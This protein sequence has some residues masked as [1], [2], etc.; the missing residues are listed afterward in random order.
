MN[1]VNADVDAIVSGHT[2]LAYN[3][4]VPV[5][6]W[7][8]PRAS[9]RSVRSS[10]RA[11]T[12]PTSTSSC[13]PS[14]PA[15]D[16]LAMAKTRPSSPAVAD[17][18]GR[19][20]PPRRSSTTWRRPGG[21]AGCPSSARSR[22][23]SSRPSSNGT[24]ENR[25]GESTLGNL[26]AEVQRW[27]TVGDRRGR[28]DRVHEPRA[29]SVP[30]WWAPARGR[31]GP[32]LPQAAD[33]QPFAN[34]LVNMDLTGAQIKDGPRAAVAEQRRRRCRRGRSSGSVRP[35]ASSTPTTR[36]CPRTRGSRGCG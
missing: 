16:V 2:H 23:R 13:S 3:H 35:R 5:R 30:T 33:V 34:T 29:A 36:A 1:N 4:A 22:A 9:S 20:R 27:A 26:V 17:D 28:A 6:P 25:G 19:R 24:T 8:R 15:S 32:D 10:R 12:A 18:P 11:S 31:P 21:A 7:G 14:T